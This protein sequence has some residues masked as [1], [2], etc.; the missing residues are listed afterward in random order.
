MVHAIY[1]G[2]VRVS[3]Y[4]KLADLDKG[5]FIWILLSMQDRELSSMALASLRWKLSLI[6]LVFATV[7][8]TGLWYYNKSVVQGDE[9][10]KILLSFL[11]EKNV[12]LSDYTDKVELANTALTSALDEAKNATKAKSEFQDLFI[13]TP[14]IS[15]SSEGRPWDATLT[16]I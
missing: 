9:E 4:E 2:L 3:D 15:K 11:E 16:P 14:S 12:Q 5:S 13:H 8:G 1:D 7:G 6:F 10:R